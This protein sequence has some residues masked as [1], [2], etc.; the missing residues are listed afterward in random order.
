[1]TPSP[2]RHFGRS[3]RARLP[4]LGPLARRFAGQAVMSATIM[5]AL[6]TASLNGV[7][8]A[9]WLFGPAEEARP[10]AAG[11]DAAER[12][13]GA[14]DMRSA[15]IRIVAIPTRDVAPPI[16]SRDGRPS[17][18]S[19]GADGES[20]AITPAP[21]KSKTAHKPS[22]AGTPASI[23]D[24][25]T[26]LPLPALVATPTPRPAFQ[27]NTVQPSTVQPLARQPGTAQPNVDRPRAPMFEAALY[28]EPAASKRQVEPAPSPELVRDD[29]PAPMPA[30][31]G[32]SGLF[33]LLPG[34]RRLIASGVSAIET[35][36]FGALE[37]GAR[38][39]AGR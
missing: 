25:H 10:A 28:R 23:A 12:D 34:G 19:E 14:D 15:P 4:P 1:M 26:P 24:E 3:I 30:A 8:P 11:R 37:T 2:S 39:I 21:L 27:R 29:V 16:T 32:G 33:G 18:L 7:A 13:A 36:A 31:D 20:N 5:T 17:Q 38:L 6:H 22:I 35:S 9:D